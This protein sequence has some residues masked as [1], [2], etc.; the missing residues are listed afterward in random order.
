MAQPAYAPKRNQ[1]S[2]PEP[3]GKRP[4][5]SVVPPVTTDIEAD[6][7]R[8]VVGVHRGAIEIALAAAIWFVAAM[9]F[10]FAT[11][12][13]AIDYPLVIVVGFAV[14]FFGLTLGLARWAARDERWFGD[15]KT[16]FRE[17]TE[18]NVDIS[19]GIIAGREALTQIIMLPVVLAIGG[20]AIGIV[21]AAGW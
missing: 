10:L 13:A 9:F 6:P 5:L 18:D 14:I 7:T 15:S 17:F 3:R 19:T 11:G 20:T 8:P 21:F 12:N 4:Q 1:K 2:Q 16:R